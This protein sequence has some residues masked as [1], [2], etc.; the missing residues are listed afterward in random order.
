M[1]SWKENKVPFP[2]TSPVCRTA[3]ESDLPN[4]LERRNYK[5]KTSV[6]IV[7]SSVR[8]VTLWWVHNVTCLFSLVTGYCRCD[9]VWV[10]CRN[11][12]ALQILPLLTGLLPAVPRHMAR[13]CGHGL[14]CLFLLALMYTWELNS[15]VLVIVRLERSEV[16]PTKNLICSEMM[17]V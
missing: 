6:N 14:D 13:H 1:V 2:R 15:V 12:F 8:M 16:W 7:F 3:G 5:R 4:L 11:E 9:K 17:V 10:S